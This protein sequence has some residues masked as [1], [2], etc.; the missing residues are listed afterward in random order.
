MNLEVLGSQVALSCE[1]H[2][3]VLGRGVEDGGKLRGGHGG[4]LIQGKDSGLRY[5]NRLALVVVVVRKSRAA[6]EFRL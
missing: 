5:I 2:L 1:E 4:R 6:G 3:N